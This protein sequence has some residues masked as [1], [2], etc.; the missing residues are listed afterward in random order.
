MKKKGLRNKSSGE[1]ISDITP[2]EIPE[3]DYSKNV[4]EEGYEIKSHSDEKMEK[5]KEIDFNLY[6]VNGVPSRWEHNK[7]HS[8]WHFDNQMDPKDDPPV[9]NILCR[10]RGD[11]SEALK[12]IFEEAEESTI[13]NYRTRDISRQDWDLH[14]A[15]MMDVLRGTG[16]NYDDVS[17]G[18][19]LNLEVLRKN[20][21][22]D[23]D[24]RPQ[25]DVFRRMAKELGIDVH[26][27]RINCQMLGQLLPMHIDQNMRYARP[28][29]RK[30]WVE[31]GGDKDPDKLRRILI[32]LLPWDYGHVWHFGSHFYSHY[33]AG[34]AI[35]FDCWN[36]PHGT[37]NIGF[38]PRVTLQITGFISDRTRELSANGSRDLVI[39]V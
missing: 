37:S 21:E 7:R 14:E 30:I 27:M 29:W 4:D 31:G 33:P 23:I 5:H 1:L 17:C 38:S 8:N 32:N 2:K 9:Y 3:F 15:E 22:W 11:W 20:G 19:K 10:F 13:A 12:I 18:Y 34:E 39:D 28:H 16:G 24:E 26:Q 25:F 36:V 35:S 6:S